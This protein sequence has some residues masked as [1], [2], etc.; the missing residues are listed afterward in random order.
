MRCLLERTM[1]YADSIPV[2]RGGTEGLVIIR[3]EGLSIPVRA[4]CLSDRLRC[5]MSLNCGRPGTIQ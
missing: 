2:L 3:K 5:I 1:V 4:P